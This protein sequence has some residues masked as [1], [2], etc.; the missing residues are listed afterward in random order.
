MGPLWFGAVVLL[1]IWSWCSMPWHTR[2]MLA[3]YLTWLLVGGALGAMLYSCIV[4]DTSFPNIP[5]PGV[6][7]RF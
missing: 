2:R 6:T 1:L 7:E 3:S 4:L 5:L